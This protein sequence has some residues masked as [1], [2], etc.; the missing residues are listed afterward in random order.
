QAWAK[1]EA[2]EQIADRFHELIPDMA[3]D[4]PFELD[5]F[6]KECLPSLLLFWAGKW[7][8]GLGWKVETDLYTCVTLY[9]C[10]NVPRRFSNK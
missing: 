6:Q 10:D 3:L 4:F 1:L 8:P 7:T 2:S 9:L 5:A